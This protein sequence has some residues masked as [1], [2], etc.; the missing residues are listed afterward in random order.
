MAIPCPYDIVACSIFCQFLYGRNKPGDTPGKPILYCRPKPT[1]LNISHMSCGSSM[2]EILLV[3]ILDDFWITSCT[4]IRPFGCESL[5]TAPPIC[6]CPAPVS[7]VLSGA[8]FRFSK[9]SATVKGLSVDPGSKISVTAR[10][11]KASMSILARVLG[12][13]EG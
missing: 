8:I 9:A 1:A 11:R 3:P 12:S 7:I 4:V 6:N 13:Y 5:I 2:K 10:L